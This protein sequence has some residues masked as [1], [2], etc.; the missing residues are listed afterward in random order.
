MSSSIQEPRTFF[1][2]SYVEWSNFDWYSGLIPAKFRIQNGVETSKITHRCDEQ[3]G[4]ADRTDSLPWLYSRSPVTPNDLDHPGPSTSH[5]ISAL[6]KFNELIPPDHDALARFNNRPDCCLGNIKDNSR[7]CYTST[8]A[9]TNAETREL[10]RQFLTHLA[11]M[12]ITDDTSRVV[13]QLEKFIDTAVCHKQLGSLKKNVRMLLKP[14]SL[15]NSTRPVAAS[16]PDQGNRNA[17][18][19]VP[20][21]F[22]GE[23]ITFW[24]P[25]TP[26][27]SLWY[28]PE[29]LPY[30]AYG[31]SSLSASEWVMK[32]VKEPLSTYKPNETLP[33]YLY[34]YWNQAS[35]GTMKIGYTTKDV[36][37]RLDEWEADCQ[38]IAQELYRS[39]FKV[40]NAARLERLV[41]ADLNDFR[42]FETLCRSCQTCHIEWFKDVKFETVLEK[43]EFW[44]NWMMKRPYKNNGRQ[45]LLSAEAQQEVQEYSTRSTDST[46]RAKQASMPRT[47]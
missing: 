18:H 17:N 7:R 27:N 47:P 32:E 8:R 1:N 45:W 4:T 15:Q 35:F 6:D 20:V 16:A 29:Y 10:I 36:R 2:V 9:K 26:T 25:E 14:V 43:I 19:A 44:T 41:H 21:A 12:R 46:S 37:V 38:H 11:A 40:N 31:S 23:R 28:L 30:E 39:P 24:W 22:R 33:G 5:F 34:V 42:V 13:T 3:I